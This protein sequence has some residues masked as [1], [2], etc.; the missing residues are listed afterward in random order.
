M[1]KG[2]S[3]HT[4]TQGVTW[5]GTYLVPGGGLISIHTP[6]QGVTETSGVAIKIIGISIHTPTQGVTFHR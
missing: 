3:I 2:I 5:S 6:T 1:I 4:P